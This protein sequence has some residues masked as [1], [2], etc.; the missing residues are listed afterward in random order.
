MPERPRPGSLADAL[1]YAQV[2]TML[3]APMIAGGA[4]GYWLDG[5]WGL[6]P[7]LMLAGLLVGMAG[8]FVN[9]FNL[10]LPRK[11]DGGDPGR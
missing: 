1:K 11:D 10:V 9:F 5:K 4:L 6:R 3:V 7:W 8:G 2:G